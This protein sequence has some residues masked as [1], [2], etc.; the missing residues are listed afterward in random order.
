MIKENEFVDKIIYFCENCLPTI[1]P[2]SPCSLHLNEILGTPQSKQVDLSDMLKLYLFLVQHLIGTN[3]PAKPVLVIPLIS[4]SFN[5]EMKVPTSVEDLRNQIDIS[6][7]PSLIL[8]D[9]QHNKLVAPCE[10][11]CSPLDFQLL[12]SSQDQVYI[13]YREF[14]YLIGKI[15]SWE[16]SRAIYAEYYPKGLVTQ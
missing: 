3:L 6:E 12:D 9:W 14:R 2:F 10:E 13:Y 11:Y 16:Y 7:P 1:T 15:N 4:Q 5:I 8:L